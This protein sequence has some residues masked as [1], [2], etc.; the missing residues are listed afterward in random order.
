MA[1]ELTEDELREIFGVGM[2]TLE[3]PQDD[4]RLITITPM[5]YGKFRLTIGPSDIGVYDD[6]W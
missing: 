5:T 4:G 6:S 1:D 3:F 2:P